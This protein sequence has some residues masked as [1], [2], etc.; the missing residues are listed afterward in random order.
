MKQKDAPKVVAST[1]L[2]KPTKRALIKR[3]R[4]EGFRS[5]SKWLCTHLEEIAAQE[6]A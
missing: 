4:R 2:P 5:F 1:R 6:A 3:A